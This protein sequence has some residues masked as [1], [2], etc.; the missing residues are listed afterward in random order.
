MVLY[1]GARH[2]GPP[3]VAVIGTRR[4]TRARRI[5]SNPRVIA[6]SRPS[7]C[8]QRDS[9]QMV[10]PV[11]RS[12]S[13]SRPL[14]PRLEP[15]VCGRSDRPCRPC[16]S[17]DR[18][19]SG[20]CRDSPGGRGRGSAGHGRRGQ[21][22][23]RAERGDADHGTPQAHRNR[24]HAHVHRSEHEPPCVEGRRSSLLE[25]NRSDRALTA[26]A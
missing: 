16:A 7:A 12:G 2:S 3:A 18:P 6:L 24:Q 23:T 15:G 14:G 13:W 26:R 10:A 21:G 9:N 4:G 5:S 1:I 20:L 11:H 8:P 17:L 22:E 25:P 19:R